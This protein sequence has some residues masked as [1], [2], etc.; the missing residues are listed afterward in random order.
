MIPMVSI[1]LNPAA[2]TALHDMNERL[3]S[4]NVK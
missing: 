4:Y 3:M 1:K 2:L